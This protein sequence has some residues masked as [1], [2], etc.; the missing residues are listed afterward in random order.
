MHLP[1]TPKNVTIVALLVAAMATLLIT[2]LQLPALLT[3]IV[4]AALGAPD[5]AASANRGPS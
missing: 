5:R 1:S 3:A 4:V 2:A